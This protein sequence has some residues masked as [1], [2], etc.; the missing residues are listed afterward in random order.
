MQKVFRVFFWGMLVSFLGSLPLGTM[1]ITITQISV[2]QG[3]KNGFAFA[4]GSMMVEVVIVRVALVSMKW[5]AKQHRIFRILEY[6]TTSIILFLSIASF[7]A[8]YKMNGFASSLPIES[9]TPFW[10]GVF[11]SFTN[12]LHIPFWLGWSIV[13]MDKN[14]LHVNSVEYNWYVAGIGV[15]TIFGFAVFIYAGSLLVNKIQEHQTVLNCLIGTVLLITAI[16]QIRKM[17]SMPA[18]VR[19][20]KLN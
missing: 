13:L 17:I 14:I 7:I 2:Q 9:L 18:S 8:A 3:T 11:L 5:L 4:I 12:P 1:N 10:S 6:L 15:G 16:V 19:Y 20:N